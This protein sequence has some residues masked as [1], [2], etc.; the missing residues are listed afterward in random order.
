[1]M[2]LEFIPEAYHPMIIAIEVV[3]DKVPAM[4]GIWI[5]ISLDDS[6]NQWYRQNDKRQ[7]RYRIR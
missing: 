4:K 6:Y 7:N 5:N 2:L 1:M 3:R